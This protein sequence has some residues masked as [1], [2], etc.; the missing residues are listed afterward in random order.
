MPVLQ[1]DQQPGSA[2]NR[3]RISVNATEIPDRAPLS[4]DTDIEFELAVSDSE[5]FRWYLED[6]LQFD[7]APAPQIAKGIEALMVECGEELFCKI[8]RASD[9]ARRLWFSLEPYLSTT[10]IEIATGTVE[11]TAIPWEL[12]RDPDSKTYL[13]LSAA[14]FV[15]SQRASHT[16][17]APAAEAAK[18]RLLF[19]LSRPRDSK[20]VP[21][22]SV[23]GRLVTQLSGDARDAFDID[24]LRPP[25]YEQLAATLQRARER[26]QPY[27]IVQFD[28]RGIGAGPRHLAAVGKAFGVSGQDAGS[29]G[30]HG[31]LMFENPGSSTTE[32]LVDGF[33]LG[34]LLRDNSVLVLVLNTCQPAFVEA[35][36]KPEIKDLV[37]TREEVEAYGALAQSV[38]EAGAAGVV[39]MRY[40]INVD[41]AAQ[42]V[43]ELYGALARGRSLGEAATWA[44]KNLNASPERQIAYDPRP[45]QDWSVPVVWE[46]APLRLWKEKT[47]AASLKLLLNETPAA[48]SVALDPTLP[49]RPDTGFFGRDETLYALDRAFDAQ[50]IVLLHAYAGSGKTSTAAEF[51]RWYALTDGIEGPV[52]FTSFER[53]LPLARVLDKI[54]TVFGTALQKS[55]IEWDA[56]TDHAQR[57]QIALQVLQ[58]I[59]VLWIWDNVEPVTGFPA[60]GASD[61]SNEE[62][63]ELRTFLSAARDTRAK[64]LLTSRR[65]ETSWLGDLVARVEVPAL[66][67]QECLQLAAA[68][69]ARRGSRLAELPDLR[70]LLRFTHGNP[71][72]IL[73]TV[74]QALRAGIDNKQRLDAFVTALQ[75]GE[76]AFGHEAT[77]GRS[78]SLGAA[79]S[80]GFAVA[81]DERDRPI[82][83]LLH[84]FQGFVD[85]EALGI[86]GA[87]GSGWC[88]EAVR[89]LEREQC[90]ALFDHAAEMG[91]L[92]AHGS[93]YYAI[94]PA[95]PWYFRM[96]FAQYFPEAT[97]AAEQAR[98]AFVKAMRTLG[99]HYRGQY[100]D[101]NREVLSVLALEED[102][103]IA[104]WR[105]ARAEGWWD[106]VIPIMRALGTL[107]G[108]TGRMVAWRRLVTELSA[109]VI[110]PENDG[111][112]PG[113]E[114]EWRLVTEYRVQL[115]IEEREWNVAERLQR[116]C[117]DWDRQRERSNHPHRNE[118]PRSILGR[119][120]CDLAY[121]QEEQGNPDCVQTYRQ[122]LEVAGASEDATLQS[123][124]AM[125]LG[126]AF[127][128]INS[129]RDLDE[130]ERWY[131]RSLELAA[132]SDERARS[133]ILAQLG[134]VAYERFDE[135]RLQ[136]RPGEE[137]FGFLDE[138]TQLYE[139]ALDTISRTGGP[140][141]AALHHQLGNIYASAGDVERAFHHYRQ[142]IRYSDEAGDMF[143]AGETR[144][145]VAVVLLEAGRVSDARAYAEAALNNF[146]HF[147]ERA[148]SAVER[149]R[150]LISTIERIAKA[151]TGPK[152]GPAANAASSVK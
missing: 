135:A 127:L 47:G 79:L 88:C 40:L 10:R 27:H 39:A 87:P 54:G 70:P 128:S 56:I 143:G 116:L 33:E 23:A 144:F 75:G 6:Y 102:N 9:E 134:R 109:E 99:E 51:A 142:G 81:F 38:M 63:Q 138:S 59:S 105:L 65:D 121:L 122:A 95:L 29:G 115:A 101:G 141:R 44:R 126:N 93:G 2:P 26:G 57:R 68:I 82:L 120:L 52:L 149:A 46:R 92:V 94:H 18:V 131:R 123:H 53:Y 118:K 136:E 103:L 73:V 32:R 20:D 84:L 91:L 4:F 147:G 37:D 8:F 124:I 72:T 112:L 17:L 5:R 148:S 104:A 45:L 12:I 125:Q 85:V 130:A 80:Y 76:V 19:V 113:R 111:A 7:E 83:A 98:Q 66:P 132:G 100:L 69:V 15:R 140:D 152:S 55:G 1:I 3:Y 64:F 96:L 151:E 106:D 14:A 90:I 11:A 35:R 89:G 21:F 60:G 150:L 139:Q 117:V 86:M 36:F 43:A 119:S 67:M 24:V 13:A 22:R 137:L 28:G 107:Y 78:R 110:D 97:G 114:S 133:R 41:T 31:F 62:Q 61:W 145:N 58:Q 16:V 146:M 49:P 30:A 50:P 25:T 108:V 129:Q 34:R 48:T 77:E 71:L 74:A 42:F